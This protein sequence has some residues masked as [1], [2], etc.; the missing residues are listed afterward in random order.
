M[1][2]VSNTAWRQNADHNFNIHFNIHRREKL[3]SYEIFIGLHDRM[4]LP[5]LSSIPTAPLI[6]SVVCI[7]ILRTA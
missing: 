4:G 3:E 2:T 5:P 1:E 6:N 7:I